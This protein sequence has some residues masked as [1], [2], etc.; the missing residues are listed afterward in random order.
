M[1][2]KSGGFAKDGLEVQVVQRFSAQLYLQCE[3]QLP[4]AKNHSEMV[5][6]ASWVDTTYQTVVKYMRLCIG[7]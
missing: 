2:L 6:F 4:V 7:T 5:K 1:Q 3:H